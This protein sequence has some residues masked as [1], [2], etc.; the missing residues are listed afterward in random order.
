MSRYFSFNSTCGQASPPMT[1]RAVA[2]YGLDRLDWAKRS[3][4]A[5]SSHDHN[6]PDS[7]TTT[8]IPG[9]KTTTSYEHE[10]RVNQTPT[11]LLTFVYNPHTA[12]HAAPR[13]R[14]PAAKLSSPPPPSSPARLD[15]PPASLSSSA[16]TTTPR[17]C[18]LKRIWQSLPARRSRRPGSSK[19]ELWRI[20]QL[21][22]R[23]NSPSW[24]PSRTASIKTRARDYGAELQQICQ[25]LGIEALLQCYK[26]LCGE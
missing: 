5:G 14:R 20:R 9:T 11:K 17:W 19:P 6:S 21:H 8:Q 4:P 18:E 26:L 2:E 10:Y 23:P 1:A 7:Y 25:C 22:G 12:H 15:R 13:L 3:L 24:L 16:N